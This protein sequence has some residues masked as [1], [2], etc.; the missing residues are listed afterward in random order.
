[1]GWEEVWRGR[2]VRW[3]VVEREE[4]VRS[5]SVEEDLVVRRR[6]VTCRVRES[7]VAT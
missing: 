3:E 2:R 6:D 7:I 4:V 5:G 1:M